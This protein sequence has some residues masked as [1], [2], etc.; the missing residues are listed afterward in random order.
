MKI[1]FTFDLKLI[2][3]KYLLFCMKFCVTSKCHNAAVFFI[4]L[5][6]IDNKVQQCDL[7]KKGILHSVNKFK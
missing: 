6:D 3:S 5:C 4:L 2:Q 1:E 7:Q